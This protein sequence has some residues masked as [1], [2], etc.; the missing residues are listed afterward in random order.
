MDP[1]LRSSRRKFFKQSAL[2]LAGAG[3]VV[4]TGWTK[5]GLANQETVLKIRKYRLLGRTG[6]K[7]S[8]ISAGSIMDEGVLGTALDA[9]VNYIDTAEQYPGHHRVVAKVL[10]GRDRASVFISSKLEILEDKS[11]EGFLNRTHKCLEELETDYID[12]MMIHMA[13]TIDMLK[14]EGFH[15]AMEQLKKEGKI[16]FVGA[17]HHGSFWFR[18]PEETMEKVLLAGVEDGRF[19]VFLLAHNF[20]QM[21]QGERVLHECRRKNIGT[22]LMKTTPVAIYYGIKANIEKMEE[23]GKEI[24]P[25][26]ADGFKSYKEKYEKAEAFIKTHDL[27]N[28]EEIK[29]AAVRFALDNPNVSSVCCLPK[30]FDDLDRFLRLSGSRFNQ[31]DMDLLAAYKKGCGELY[32]R[33]ACGICEPEC[34]KGVPVNTIMRYNQYFVQ[35]REKETMGLY[36]RIPG[37]KADAC[38]DCRGYCERACPFNVPVQ[39]MLLAADRLLSL[40]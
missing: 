16:R 15:A 11:K 27:Q 19:D 8:D 39:G 28:P 40:A 30:T 32:C 38:Q 3:L 24:H 31:K 37:K 20:L 14:T 6:F 33:H 21:N 36:A 26:Y 23:E 35:G 17:S 22:V 9:G 25:L 29:E 18:E 5:A 1:K 13:E 12:C 7:V 2:G 4:K 10:K 34:P